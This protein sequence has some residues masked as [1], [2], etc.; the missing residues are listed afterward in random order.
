M[1]KVQYLLYLYQACFRRVPDQAGFNAWIYPLAS[2]V[3]QNSLIPTFLS[4]AEAQTLWPGCRASDTLSSC[5][6]SGWAMR[7]NLLYS[8]ILG[9][10]ADQAGYNNYYYSGQNFG[11]LFFAFPNAPELNNT[12]GP[13]VANYKAWAFPPSQNSIFYVQAPNAQQRQGQMTGYQAFTIKQYEKAGKTLLQAIALVAKQTNDFGLI[14]ENP[15]QSLVDTQAAIYEG[16]I[17]GPQSSLPYNNTTMTLQ[18]QQIIAAGGFASQQAAKN[19]IN[20]ALS[21]YY[22][23]AAVAQ[24]DSGYNWGAAMPYEPPG[25]ISNPI[26]ASGP[27]PTSSGLGGTPIDYLTPDDYAPPFTLPS[28]IEGGLIS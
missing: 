19:Q 16:Q 13:W 27:G 15:S 3:P 7:I 5:G 10:P 21:N 9:R 8:G 26:L 11:Q 4:S 20:T 25:S 24:F 14:S 28:P 17:L 2:G 23:P 12:L 22:T 1:D 18:A 6:S